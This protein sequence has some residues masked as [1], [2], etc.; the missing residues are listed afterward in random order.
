MKRLVIVGGG[1]AGILVS[2]LLS[3]KL[4]ITVIEPNDYHTY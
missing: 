1:N 3:R 4:E 2:N